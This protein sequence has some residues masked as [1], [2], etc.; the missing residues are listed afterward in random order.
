V[1]IRS[2]HYS[3][4]AL[5][6]AFSL[7]PVKAF[8]IEWEDLK[9]YF[10]KP[11]RQSVHILNN[12]GSPVSILDASV[13]D[14][15]SSRFKEFNNVFDTFTVN[16]KNNTGRTVLSYEISWTIKHPFENYVYHTIKTNSIDPLKPSQVQDLKFKRDKHYRDDVYYFVEVTRVQFSDSDEVWQAPIHET[17]LS[18]WE[19]IKTQINSQT[20]GNLAP[21]TESIIK[22]L[23]PVNGAVLMKLKNILIDK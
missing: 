21:S 9:E 5:I 6:L 15:G 12:Y 3:L 10:Q 4:I 11:P 22:D 23:D 19:S 20:N 16:V 2:L 13:Y 7:S 17:S 14:Q 8:L 1:K 18:S